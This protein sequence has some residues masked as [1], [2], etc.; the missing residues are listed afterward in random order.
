VTRL[1]DRAVS[2]MI[3]EIE[4]LIKKYKFI[5]MGSY[6]KYR[7]HKTLW[8]ITIP[9][10]VDVT[11]MTVFARSFPVSFVPTIADKK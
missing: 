8:I 3:R 5:D 11:G 10:R 6:V 4:P 7:Y 9:P 2:E 1:I